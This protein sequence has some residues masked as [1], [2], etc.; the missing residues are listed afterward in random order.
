MPE[1]GAERRPWVAFAPPLP[2]LSRRHLPKGKH[3]LPAHAADS[4]PLGGDVVQR[5]A[6]RLGET[7]GYEEGPG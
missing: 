2:H 3:G 4:G 5:P 6:G 7:P 1:A